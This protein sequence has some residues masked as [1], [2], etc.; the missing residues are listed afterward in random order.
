MDKMSV[1]S[2]ENNYHIQQV[3]VE[4]NFEAFIALVTE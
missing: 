1:K 2:K 3:F 4:N